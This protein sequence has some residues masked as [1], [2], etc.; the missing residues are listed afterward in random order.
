M[1][2]ENMPEESET[3]EYDNSDEFGVEVND[4][5]NVDLE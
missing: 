2:D 1:I 4:W 3:E 5:N